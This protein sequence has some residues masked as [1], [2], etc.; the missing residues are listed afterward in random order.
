MSSS[1]AITTATNSAHLDGN[2]QGQVVFTVSNT[3][4]RPVRGRARIAPDNAAA[5]TWFTLA[6]GA[7]RDF[8][9]NGTQQYTL[10]IAVPPT[11]AAGNYTVRLDMVGVDNPD[12]DFT[13]GP[14]VTIAVPAPLAVKKPFP[15][16]IIAVIVVA[17][18]AIVFL[19]SRS[20]QDSAAK[21]AAEATATAAALQQA[22]NAANATA[23]ARTA[24]TA[25]AAA[26]AAG[27]A[28]ATAQAEAANVS[29]TATAQASV[30]TV[31]A[32]ATNGVVT[33][34]NVKLNG[35]GNVATMSP[36]ANFTVSMDYFIVDTGCPG[37]VD[38]IQIGYSDTA[39]NV[40]AY[41]G[42]PG[43]AGQSGS[44]NVTL[45]APAAAGTY[46][47]GFDRSQDFSCP[48]HWWNSPPDASRYIA[49][50]IVK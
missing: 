25:T 8:S 27:S 44:G 17:L 7:E 40:C 4:V 42:I 30:P 19:I 28:T 33:I 16:W 24:A 50:I 20:G 34:S 12:E 43:T 18:I 48:N 47:I 9:V 22:A 39:P 41:S 38:Q 26:Q 14:S 46:F 6:G 32:Q 29:A 21:Q 45:T 49:A 37:C 35:G 1:F 31:P 36:G 23:A 5:A 11:T 15:W 2:R 13:Q 10:Q 3:S